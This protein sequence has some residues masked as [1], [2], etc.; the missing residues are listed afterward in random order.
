MKEGSDASKSTDS[1]ATAGDPESLRRALA[2]AIEKQKQQEAVIK[3]LRHEVD[4][5]R[6]HA[7]ILRHDNQVLR[8]MKANM[9]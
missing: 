4:V 6:G 2:E 5:E 8:Q 9:V 7:T 3:K 1:Q